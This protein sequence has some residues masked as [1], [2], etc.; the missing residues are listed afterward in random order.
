ML[1]VCEP[2]TNKII[3]P[4]ASLP[5]SRLGDAPRVLCLS[6]HFHHCIVFHDG[7]IHSVADEFSGCFHFAVL[8]NTAAVIILAHVSWGRYARVSL[9]HTCVCA[10]LLQS[11]LTLCG[12]VN[13]SPPGSFVHEIL[14]ARILE[15]AAMPSSLTWGSNPW[16]L[17]L[18]HCRQIIYSLSHLGSPWVYISGGKNAR[19]GICMCSLWT[20]NATMLSQ[21]AT[22]SLAPP[23]REESSHSSSSLPLLPLL[24]S[25][26]DAFLHIY[27]R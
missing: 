13:C 5:A 26:S 1:P 21:Q 6:L 19:S 12:P 3:L 25:S 4:S 9:R 14:Q 7:C 23:A 16:L 18:L 15:W 10:Q 27:W 22:P 17:C 8:M 20:I 24:P 2:Y 11:C